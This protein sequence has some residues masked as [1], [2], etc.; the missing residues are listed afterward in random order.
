[1]IKAKQEVTGTASAQ[2]G[3]FDFEELARLN[4]SPDEV[5]DFSVNSNPYGPPSSVYEA[6]T[7]VALDRYPDRECLALR[8]KLAEY[9][10]IGVDSYCLQH[11]DRYCASA[12]SLV[13]SYT[14]TGS[15]GPWS[16]RRLLPSRFLLWLI[17][18]L[19]ESRM[20]L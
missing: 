19:A 5:L 14:R 10:G 15:P 4:L 9:H 7:H 1:M 18:S 12:K 2:H 16:V 20:L 17:S 6:L 8:H 13:D 3:A 11:P